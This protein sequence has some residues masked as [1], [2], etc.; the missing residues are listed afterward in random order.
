MSASIF[1]TM[2]LTETT[3]IAAFFFLRMSLNI[4]RILAWEDLAAFLRSDWTCGWSSEVTW[5]VSLKAFGWVSNSIKCGLWG[6]R[7][8]RITPPHPKPSS[9]EPAML[10]AIIQSSADH[11]LRFTDWRWL[12]AWLDPMITSYHARSDIAHKHTFASTVQQMSV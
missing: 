8:G 7:G 9:S 6:L 11:L 1:W 12:N 2:H 5:R 3:P 10:V 4:Q